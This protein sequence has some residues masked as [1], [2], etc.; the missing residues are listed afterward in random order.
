MSRLKVVF[1]V[2]DLGL[3]GVQRLVVDFA[4]GLNSGRFQ[5]VIIT[6]LK[7]DSSFFYRDKVNSN[8]PLQTF[9]FRGFG[10]LPEW[11]KLYRY[12]RREKPDIVFTQLFMAD[13]IGRI[14]A[15]LARVPVIVTEVQNIIPT[16]PKKYI[17]VGRIL[18]RIT[19]IC[20]S[21]TAAV[22]AYAQNVIG[23]PKER[24][25]EIP[26][27]A[28]D[29][30]RF[31]IV[32]DRKAV[33]KELGIPEDAKLIVNVGRLV[34]QKGQSI[35]V[36]AMPLVL[37]EEPNCY[38]I[39]AGSGKLEKALGEKIAAAGL[40][41]KVR[42]LGDR[43]DIPE[44]L[45]SSDVFAFPSRWEG[46]GLILFECFFSKIPI[47][48]SNVGGIPDVIKN[49]E[50]G[51]LFEPGKPGELAKGILKVFREPLLAQKVTTEAFRRYGDRTVENSVR[52]MEDLFEKLYTQKTGIKTDRIDI[53]NQKM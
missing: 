18:R 40:E 46:Q 24:I 13:A 28:V 30:K 45:M 43:Q 35:L 38:A 36:E 44:L 7:K 21:T 25:A 27:N 17:I 39:I 20:I 33:R 31:A 37:K 53:K 10:D 15:Y 41:E 52:K 12:L 32:P 23:F 48:A 11:F 14:T 47:V 1:I 5:A 29:A 50:T 19:D 8:V 22:T 6:L 16:L 49:E 3:G 42:L 26:T 51:L 34:E 9:A 2:N 4:N